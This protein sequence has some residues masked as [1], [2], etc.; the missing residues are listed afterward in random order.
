MLQAVHYI[1]PKNE[2]H[3]LFVCFRKNEDKFECNLNNEAKVNLDIARSKKKRLNM[4]SFSLRK[5][6]QGIKINKQNRSHSVTR[7]TP[8]DSTLDRFLFMRDGW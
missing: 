7:A 5:H 8:E 6:S 2:Q 4:F 1:L 3:I